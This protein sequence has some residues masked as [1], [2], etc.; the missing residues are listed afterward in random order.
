[1]AGSRITQWLWKTARTIGKTVD[2]KLRTHPVGQCLHCGKEVVSLSKQVKKFCNNICYQ[3]HK[4]AQTK[5][6]RE[7]IFCLECNKLFVPKRDNHVRC[8]RTC[9]E[10]FHNRYS[11]ENRQKYQ[12]SRERFP[13]KFCGQL[14]VPE[15]YKFKFCSKSCKKQ[16][17]LR[18][19]KDPSKVKPIT[20]EISA[21][22]LKTSKHSDAIEEF[23]KA[24]GQVKVYP[25]L[26]GP[27]IPDTGST[28]GSNVDEEWSIKELADLDE[29]EDVFNMK[30]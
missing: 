4:R 17:Q 23:K 22:D 19:K 27:K 16:H 11:R 14:F 13:C 29:Y 30:N 26:P 7:P 5:V 20:R 21:D 3:R 10:N 1:M 8:S 6:V 12:S 18:L 15:H 2:E 24:G 25:S 9:R 28:K